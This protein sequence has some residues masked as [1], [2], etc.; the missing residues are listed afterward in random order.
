MNTKIFKGNFGEI[1]QQQGKIYKANGMNF[2]KV[3]INPILYRNRLQVYEKHYPEL[4]KE[5]KGMAKDGNFKMGF[6]LDYLFQILVY[7]K[8]HPET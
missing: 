7:E 8:D 4:L 1:G 5:F 6:Y 3:K 2:D